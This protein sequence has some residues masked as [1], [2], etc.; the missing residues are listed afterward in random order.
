VS[1][2]LLMLFLT[3]AILKRSFPE[4]FKSQPATK[5]LFEGARRER[6]RASPPPPR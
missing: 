4:A 3:V 6:T 2:G 5:Q 1:L